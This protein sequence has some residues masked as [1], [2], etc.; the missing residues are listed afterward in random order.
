M[1]EAAH[2]VRKIGTRRGTCFCG[3]PGRCHWRQVP[4]L[5]SL[6]RH[7]DELLRSEWM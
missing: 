6:V 4:R 3:H 1:P 2:A 7:R 5:W